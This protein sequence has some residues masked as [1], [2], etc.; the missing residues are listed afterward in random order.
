MIPKILN[1]FPEKGPTIGGTSVSIK[2]AYML[3]DYS[4]P[5]CRF[6]LR[7]VPAVHHERNQTLECVTPP[8]PGVRQFISISLDGLRWS[9]S[10]A[11]FEYQ[12]I[13]TSIPLPLTESH[14][15]LS[16][17]FCIILI[18]SLCLSFSYKIVERKLAA[19]AK[20]K[21]AAFANRTNQKEL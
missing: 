20:P 21:I 11:F 19:C 4:K 6:G 12:E 18:T 1:L 10:Q 9:E 3:T 13:A 8:G 7:Y 14:S 15:R 5:T 16:Q 17:I 2:Y